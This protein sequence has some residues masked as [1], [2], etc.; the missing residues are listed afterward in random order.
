M[1]PIHNICRT[2]ENQVSRS[3]AYNVNRLTCSVSRIIHRTD[4]EC[5]IYLDFLEM[6]SV[7]VVTAF[8]Y[9]TA[10]GTLGAHTG[11]NDNR[12]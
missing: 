1:N 9:L 12:K 3:R 6:Q 10:F 8:H 4:R 2:I 5:A 11:I 7:A